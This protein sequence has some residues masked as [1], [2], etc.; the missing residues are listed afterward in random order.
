MVWSFVVTLLLPLLCLKVQIYVPL[1][2]RST[3]LICKL[4]LESWVNLSSSGIPSC[5]FQTICGI[6]APSAL[7]LII[8][9]ESAIILCWVLT[10]VNLAVG[11]NNN[12]ALFVPQSYII[13]LCGGALT[14]GY[15]RAVDSRQCSAGSSPDWGTLCTSPRFING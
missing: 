12:F 5:L 6:G 2:S 10:S 4:P 14:T 15:I 3:G 1:S 13:I 9:E 7:Q 11:R 8:P